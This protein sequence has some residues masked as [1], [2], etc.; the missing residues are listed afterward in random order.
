MYKHTQAGAYLEVVQVLS[1]G[2]KP[3]HPPQVAHVDAS[4]VHGFLERMAIGGDEGEVD[5]LPHHLR[6]DQLCQEEGGL[7]EESAVLLK[8]LLGWGEE[9]E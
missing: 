5:A 2:S 9:R 6:D 3:S 4:R 1:G 8:D 7:V